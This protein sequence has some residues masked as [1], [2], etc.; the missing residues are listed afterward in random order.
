MTQ[1]LAGRQRC[2][3]LGLPEGLAHQDIAHPTL[4]I[5]AINYQLLV[6]SVAEVSTINYLVHRLLESTDR[7]IGTIA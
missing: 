3:L 5:F 7:S 1:N 2:A 6:L 4:D